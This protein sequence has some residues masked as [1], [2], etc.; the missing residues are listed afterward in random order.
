[1]KFRDENDRAGYV[2]N[3][4]ERGAC[5]VGDCSVHCPLY[6]WCGSGTVSFDELND[7]ILIMASKLIEESMKNL[8]GVNQVVPIESAMPHKVSEVICIR[9]HKR[10]IA[11][12]P[13]ITKLS[14]LEC[15][16]CGAGF[17]IETGEDICQE[18]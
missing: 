3:A 10:W 9:C 7:C 11:V 8:S 1:M 17:V 16:N 14:D 12:R 6:N 13:E 5:M 2:A 15:E 18:E 4:L